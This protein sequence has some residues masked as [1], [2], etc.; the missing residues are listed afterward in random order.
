MQSTSS[1]DIQNEVNSVIDHKITLSESILTNQAKNTEIKIPYNKRVEQDL[2]HDLSVFIKENNNKVSEVFDIK[3]PEFSLEVIITGSSKIT[4]QNIAD[5]FVIVMKVRQKEILYWYC[6]YK[7]YE[8]RTEDIKRVNKIDN[9]LART[10][11]YNEIKALLPDITNVNLRQRT[12]RAKKIYTLLVGIGIEK[13]QA[14]TC[15]AS[16]I[17]SLTDN[18]IQDIIICFPKKFIS[19]DD[20]SV[21]YQKMI[22]ITNCNAHVTEQTLSETEVSITTTS[23]SS[24]ISN[25]KDIVNKNDEFSEIV[26]VFDDFSDSNFDSSE[27]NEEDEDISSAILCSANSFHLFLRFC[28]RYKKKTE[29]DLWLNFET[30]QIEENTDNYMSYDCI[31]KISKFSDEKDIIIEAVHKHFPFLTYINSN[32]W[33]RD[34]FKYTD[35]EAKCPICKEVYTRYCIWDDWSCLGKDDYYYLNCSFRIDQKK[36]I[37]AKQNLL[38]I[39]AEKKRWDREC[40]REDLKRDIQFHRSGIERKE[41]SRKYCKFLTNWERLVGEELLCRSILESG[42]STV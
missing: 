24:Q 15:S 17:S 16:A 40:F 8:D 7:T 35:S 34:V 27:D 5:L 30:F 29:L 26:N 14:I 28:K 9:Q 21:K 39:Q 31:I 20:S 18:Q 13:I 32:A 25:L 37:I 38:E 1:S 19:I 12:F 23:S 3:I 11:I 42:L 6:Y 2:R 4:A 22:S 36:V 33:Y 10:L 41:D